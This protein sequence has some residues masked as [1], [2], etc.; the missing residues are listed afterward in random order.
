MAR[1]LELVVSDHAVVLVGVIT[2]GGCGGSDGNG[3]NNPPTPVLT[4]IGVSLTTSTLNVGQSTT[5]TAT[6]ADQNGAPIA[7]GTVTWSSSATTVATVSS[8]GVISAV[9]PG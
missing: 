7:T 8:S 3:I 1:V 5:A 2:G 9:A 6:G 4:S